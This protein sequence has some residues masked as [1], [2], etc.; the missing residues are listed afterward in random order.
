MRH[1]FEYLSVIMSRAC[2]KQLVYAHISYF[3]PVLHYATGV[4]INDRFCP[5][6]RHV[7]DTATAY[8]S[9]DVQRLK[10]IVTSIVNF[11]KQLKTRHFGGALGLAML[12][13]CLR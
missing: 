6:V 2:L 12:C 8:I 9:S 4:L 3:Q 7:R 5:S 10:R 13:R 1:Y 11:S